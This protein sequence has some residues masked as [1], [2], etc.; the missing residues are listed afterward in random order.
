MMKPKDIPALMNKRAELIA[1]ISIAERRVASLRIHLAAIEGTIGAFAFAHTPAGRAQRRQGA[2]N[3][4]RGQISRTVLD[5]LRR[6]G[7]A[8]SLEEIVKRIAVGN[9][10]DGTDAALAN[11]VRD[12]LARRRDGLVKK[13]WRD[14]IAVWSV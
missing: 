9:G 1:E 6:A 13:Q 14:G 7:E 2:A 12:A 3:S 4:R 8:L 11:R 10:M 5:V